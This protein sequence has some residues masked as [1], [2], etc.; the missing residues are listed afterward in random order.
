MAPQLSAQTE[1]E[2]TLLENQED[3]ADADEL[4]EQLQAFRRHPIDL[5]R[6]S[7]RTLQSLPLLSPVL[8]RDIIQE[9]IRG[10]PFRSWSDFRRRMNLDRDLWMHLRPYFVV[11]LK[12]SREEERVKLR[13]RHQKHSP[14]PSGY[15][16]GAYP[17][18]PWKGYQRISLAPTHSLRGGLLLEKDPGET[19]WNDHLVG[20][21]ETTS[22][23]GST[24]LLVGDYR[25][26]AGQGLVLWGPYGL[27]KG[28]D[29]V[30]PL[31]KRSR[32]VLGYTASDENSYLR[33]GGALQ[34]ETWAFHLTL[35]ASRTS[36]DA[37]INPDESVKT[38]S[39][40]GFHRTDSE[41]QQ[42]NC[43]DETLYGG[44]IG[45]GGPWGSVGVT[46]WSSRYAKEV[47]KTDPTRYR[48][49]FQGNRNHVLGLD[50]DFFFGRFN[51][52]GELARSKSRGWAFIGS[53]IMETQK[54]SVVF[55]YRRYDPDYQNPH[56]QGFGTGG[57]QN[58]EGCY[59]GL[60]GKIPPKTRLSLYYDLFRKPWRTYSIPV[61]TRGDDLFVQLI[62]KC[63]SSLS[64]TLRAR[65]RRGE[66]LNQGTTPGGRKID[67]LQ[68]RIHRL[69]R[70]DCT[71]HPLS[72][73]RLK[74]RIETATVRYPRTEGEITTP[75]HE[76]TGLLLYQD[77]SYHPTPR[78]RLSARWI[79]FD[80]PSYDSRIYAFENDLPGVLSISPLY[81]NGSRWYILIRWKVLRC[82]QFT[83]KFS[84]TYH[85]GVTTW[86]TGHDQIQGDTDRQFGIQLDLG[87]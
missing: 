25:V 54:F 68:D 5:N 11:S 79:T 73:L 14:N 52:C 30:A 47:K 75:S 58:E 4:L 24:R 61:P 57:T 50:Y 12:R 26:E 51:F 37:T 84:A 31:K 74:S 81:G 15:E 7:L 23:P 76:E 21:V 10:G 82:L 9:R 39:T 33:G 22:I 2:E 45:T 18:S 86:G 59:F 80:T 77:V 34:I 42:S 6:A 66:H 70:F 1:T 38:F 43:T 53:T 64:I 27:S 62:Q 19:R 46:G 65:F 41:T 13:W 85:D 48:F 40:S 87:L 36:L 17:G 71:Y 44:R 67:V 78:L 8:A 32:G 83:A 29:P 49:D 3:Q 35:L 55:S 28:A 63:S 16:T 56:G 20:Y 60:S 69:F 72:R